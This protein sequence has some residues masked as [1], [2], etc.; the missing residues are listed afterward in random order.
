MDIQNRWSVNVWCG[1][2]NGYLIG[3][4]FFEGNVND[5]AILELLRDYLPLLLEDVDLE[6]RR[7]MLPTTGRCRTAFRFNCARFF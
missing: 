5:N 1:I 6:T 7:R 2:V 3:P 4:F